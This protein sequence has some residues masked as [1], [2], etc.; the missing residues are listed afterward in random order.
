MQ[1]DP[2][3]NCST[4]CAAMT[5]DPVL[6]FDAFC[7][8]RI[9]SQGWQQDAT[10]PKGSEGFLL[11]LREIYNCRHH[12]NP[13]FL[14]IGKSVHRYQCYQDSNC[15]LTQPADN[16]IPALSGSDEPR[17]QPARLCQ[18]GL[19]PPPSYP[20]VLLPSSRRAVRVPRI[21]RNF[22]TFSEFKECLI[23]HSF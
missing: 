21:V 19:V 11:Q 23:Y 8:N 6:I 22:N 16:T 20:T 18:V 1:T 10:I 2:D 9:H 12:L 4:D 7:C 13:D 17:T 3:T 14:N 5:T 15:V